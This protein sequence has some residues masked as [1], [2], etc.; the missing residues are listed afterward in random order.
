MRDSQRPPGNADRCTDHSHEPRENDQASSW[1]ARESESERILVIMPAWNEQDVIG[2]V[3]DHLRSFSSRCDVIVVSD[4]STDATATV[5]RERGVPV[6]EL[7][8]NL[9]VGGAM[10]T[11]FQYAVR[12]GYSYAVQLDADGQHNPQDISL[13]YE[14]HISDNAD[15]VIGARFSEP[16]TYTIRGPRRWAMS[17]LSMTLSR[18]C[19]T[20]L[21]DTTSGF[22]LYSRRAL[23]LFSRHYPSAYLGD[24]IEALVIASQSGLKVRQVGVT[25][26]PRAGGEPS[27]GFIRSLIQL[28]RAT[29]S[30][31][32]A[33]T[34]PP[35]KI[36]S[37]STDRSDAT[38]ES[39]SHSVPTADVGKER[40][41]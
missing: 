7:P 41:W 21:T 18:V 22:K 23:E 6:L 12:H 25:M 5:A 11:G 33:L 30:L 17:F 16:G 2:S 15:V 24:T 27:H 4:G 9:G 29:M 31:S 38:R 10:R 26:R 35:M 1:K 3:L 39:S 40:T 20:R 19:R 37:P 36:G 34:R 14:K 8:F 13:L 28:I 32:I